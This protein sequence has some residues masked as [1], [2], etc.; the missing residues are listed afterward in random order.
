MSGF[1]IVCK[2]FS[3]AFQYTKIYL[4]LNLCYIWLDYIT[5]LNFHKWA[6]GTDDKSQKGNNKTTREIEQKKGVIDHMM[7]E[8]IQTSI[9][10][11]I[12]KDCPR[13]KI[14]INFGLKTNLS[15]IRSAFARYLAIL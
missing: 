10:L 14:S 5:R 6:W 8:G 15:E 3:T 9:T 1:K 11:N 13:N 7:A 12:C 2:C 4:K